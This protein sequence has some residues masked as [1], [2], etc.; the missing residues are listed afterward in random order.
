MRIGTAPRVASTAVALGRV[1]VSQ[2]IELDIALRPRNPAALSS[3]ATAVSSPSSPLYRRYL[4]PGAFGSAFGA[5]SATVTSTVS[6]LRRLGLGAGKVSSNRLLIKV[7]ATAGA[8]ERAF[9][10]TIVRYRLA[11]GAVFYANRAAPR[12]PASIAG[13]IQAIAGLDDLPL[14]RPESLIGPVHGA[15]LRIATATNPNTVVP[16]GPR[17]CLQA[18]ESASA[19]GGPYT[20]D[21]IASA[22]GFSELYLG[23]DYGAG[24]SV[25]VFELE[26]FN[27]ADVRAYDQCYYGTSQGASMS[28]APQLNVVTVDGAQYGLASPR[29]SS[30]PSTL[31]R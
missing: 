13:G 18:S 16:G 12:I 8:V 1:S 21:E 31:R 30:P 9:H 24:V 27:Q 29:T 3:F 11:S 14:F 4:R 26:A 6:A 20:A 28:S 23:G 2:P 22:Y 17:P 25:A 7:S 19:N 5:T 10:T 15:K